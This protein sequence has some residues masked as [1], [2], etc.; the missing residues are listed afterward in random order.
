[1][2]PLSFLSL[3]YLSSPSSCVLEHVFFSS[4]SFCLSCPFVSSVLNIPV[5]ASMLFLLLSFVFHVFLLRSFSFV[6]CLLLETVFLFLLL[7]CLFVTSVLLLSVSV[8]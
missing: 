7:S 8:S 5:F 2:F 6:V 4:S 1:M 3:C